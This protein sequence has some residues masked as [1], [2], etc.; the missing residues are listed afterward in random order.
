MKRFVE[1]RDRGQSN[2]VSRGSGWLRWRID[3]RHAGL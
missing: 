3:G 1:G 2:A